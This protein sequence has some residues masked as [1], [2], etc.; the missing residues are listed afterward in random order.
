MAFTYGF[1]NSENGD[2]KYNAREF[3]SIFDGVIAD[4]VFEHVGEQLAVTSPENG[5]KVNIGTGRAWLLHTWTLNTAAY[6]AYLEEPEVM[7]DRYDAV[8]L[9]VNHDPEYRCNSIHVIKGIE[10]VQ[11]SA[12][13]YK[14]AIHLNSLRNY[15]DTDDHKQVPLAY[16]RVRAKSSY[17]RNSDIVNAVGSSKCP[18][19]TGIIDTLNID[20]LMNQWRAQFEEW[21]DHNGVA[22]A[23]WFKHIQY[24]LDG[25]VAG[26]LQRQIDEIAKFA[27]IYVVDNVL[28]LPMSGASIV[29][30]RLKF[31]Q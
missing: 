24:E 27:H 28:Y 22:W 30:K 25:D 6:P 10:K 11:P 12:E 7:L 13:T 2:R 5:F 16:V 9:D 14:N 4:G 15:P 18:V 23:E 20:G 1:Y 29:G 31:A 21:L 19:V 3:G 8:V 17:I 26:H